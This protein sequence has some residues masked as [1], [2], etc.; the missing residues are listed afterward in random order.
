MKRRFT[1][2]ST[3]STETSTETGH[4]DRINR[5]NRMEDPSMT[6]REKV[7]EGVP[8]SRF[9]GSRLLRRDNISLLATV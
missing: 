3:E 9:I 2:E 1:T 7:A 4:S 8:G 6:L 5:I